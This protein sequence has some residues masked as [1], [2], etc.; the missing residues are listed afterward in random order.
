MTTQLPTVAQN[1]CLGLR[2]FLCCDA[3]VPQ[4]ERRGGHA[5]HN[6]FSMPRHSLSAADQ[7]IYEQ[8]NIES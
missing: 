1:G 2:N 6:N 5:G 3:G 7:M 4:I 8:D